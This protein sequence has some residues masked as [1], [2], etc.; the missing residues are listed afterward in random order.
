MPCVVRC[1]SYFFGLVG[2][3]KEFIMTILWSFE[4]QV[5]GEKMGKCKEKWGPLV[6]KV[7][8]HS[9]GG[10]RTTLFSC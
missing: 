10:A 3:L 9:R 7:A 6:S 8:S 5:R 1:F 2:N 4:A